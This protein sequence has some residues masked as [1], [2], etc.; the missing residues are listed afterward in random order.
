MTTE[1]GLF[2]DI[3]TDRQSATLCGDNDRE[4]S[5]YIRWAR[6]VYRHTTFYTDNSL[7][8][9]NAA[10]KGIV[11]VAWLIE[12]PSRFNANYELASRY[13]NKFTYV[14]T[15]NQDVLQHKNNEKWRYLPLGG[16]SIDPRKAG[17][18][19]KSKL[20][21]MYFPDMP[22][23]HVT[24]GSVL[25][26]EILTGVDLLGLD[27]F[28]H[29]AESAL[30]GYMYSIVVEDMLLD[31][32]FSNKLIDCFSQGTIPIYYGSQSMVTTYFDTSGMYFF[33]NLDELYK[34]V[35]G[36]ATPENYRDKKPAVIHNFEQSFNYRCVENQ[37][38]RNYPD[39]F[40][41]R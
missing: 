11:N 15:Y 4:V 37:I 12:L 9:V 16:S 22:K 17:I 6:N 40:R 26:E 25:Q 39:M 7:H 34:I 27:V 3:F 21:S 29:D 33:R 31:G 10:P 32:Y 36:E 20:V 28:P 38:M 41:E 13:D 8:E 19:G 23:S 2:D 5:I 14:L 1:A 24:E 18:H 35:L 30:S